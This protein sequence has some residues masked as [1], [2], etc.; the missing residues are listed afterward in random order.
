[1]D[2]IELNQLSETDK[3]KLK[4]VTKAYT[5][6]E[7]RIAL[8]VIPDDH[9]WDELIRR[10]TSMMKGVDHIAK[11]LDVSLDSITPISAKAWDEMKARYDDLKN[12]FSK[13]RQFFG[14]SMQ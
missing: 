6:E 13:I 7:C 5:E 3:E 10:N 2:T 11:T 1:M 12:K 4:E 14:G 9:L 8:K